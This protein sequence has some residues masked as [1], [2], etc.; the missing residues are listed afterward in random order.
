MQRVTVEAW[1]QMGIERRE[2]TFDVFPQNADSC[3]HCWYQAQFLWGWT[4]LGLFRVPPA[5]ETPWR[6]CDNE[7][8]RA[9]QEA[10]R[11]TRRVRLP[12]WDAKP[13]RSSAVGPV[14][15]I[16]PHGLPGDRRGTPIADSIY[17]WIQMG[18]ERRETL[19]ELTT[20]DIEVV[21]APHARR[22][23]AVRNGIVASVEYGVWDWLYAQ[24]GRGWR[25]PDDQTDESFMEGAEDGGCGSNCITSERLI[26]NTRYIR[27]PE[28]QKPHL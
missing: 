17:M 14:E 7:L 1:I 26:P 5:A 28:V 21:F 23:E 3:V 8:G 20:D 18:T 2:T 10:I 24:F 22:H 6:A 19:Q 27:L 15:R 9:L 13:I 25:T 4:G 16:R 12:E 11:N